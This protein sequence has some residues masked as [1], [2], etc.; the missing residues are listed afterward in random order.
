L[1]IF[2]AA[3]VQIN[4]L[5]PGQVSWRASRP[6][7]AASPCQEVLR[8]LLGDGSVHLLSYSVADPNPSFNTILWRLIRPRDGQAVTLE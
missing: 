8:W 5:T 6:P 7:A 4:T 1:N 3:R 2:V